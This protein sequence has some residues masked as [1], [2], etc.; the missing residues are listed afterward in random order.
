MQRLTIGELFDRIALGIGERE[1]LVFP[2]HGVR[3]GYR[4][5]HARVAQVAKGLMG[6]GVDAG[7]H[8]AVFAT[9]RPEWVL[10]QLAVAKIGAVLVPIDPASGAPELAHVLAHS[11]ASAL[12]LIDQADGVSLVDVLVQGCPE[13]RDAKPGRLVSRRFPFLKRVALLGE[14]GDLD[15]PGV[16]SWSDVLAAG[17][18]ITDHL[19]RRRQ[20]AI[21][22][23]DLAGIHYTAGTTG[24]PKGVELTHLNLVNNALAAGDCMRLGRRDRL[25]V[26]V[27]LFR[28]F[29]CVLGTLTAL[30][31][32]ATMVVPADHF[33]A[34]KTLTAIAEERCTALHGEPR[35][36]GSMVRHPQVIRVDVSSLRTGIVMGAPCPVELMPEIVERLH[37]REITVAYGQSEAT[38]VITQTRPEDSLDTKVT[39]VGRSLPDV[40]VKIVDPKTGIEVPV[41][42]EGELC[43][44]GHLVMRGYYKMPEASAATLGRNGWLRTG[45]LAVMDQY[46]YCAI[47]GRVRQPPGAV[48]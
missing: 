41:G 42:G 6:L 25:C 32:G 18:G 7:D 2:D 30:G 35:M 33:D 22:P 17:A 47:T 31:R 19:V 39:T 12:F 36:L 44:R 15:L 9:N 24:P 38:A 45:D 46:G 20:E 48:S 27:P 28:P 40:E 3:W 26:P 1:A 21:E 34:G 4:D 5:T 10:L 8:V 37:A 13:L 16:L 29:G 43:C 14:T 11:D 23:A